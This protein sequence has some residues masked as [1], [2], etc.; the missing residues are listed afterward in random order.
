VIEKRI[1][2][3]HAIKTSLQKITQGMRRTCPHDLKK[4]H[5]K[6]YASKRMRVQD[7]GILGWRDMLVT[8]AKKLSRTS[9]IRLTT[10]LL[11]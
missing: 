6:A 9:Q 4:I 11:E 1:A 3:G 10:E 5:K 7:R 2:Q 8:D